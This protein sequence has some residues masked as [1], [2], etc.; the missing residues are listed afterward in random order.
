MLW[1]QT[2]L[3]EPSTTTDGSS[4]M[5]LMSCQLCVCVLQVVCKYLEDP[6]LFNREEVGMV[7]FD[8]RYML[9][10]RSVE[11]LHVYAYNV[12]WLRFANRYDMYSSS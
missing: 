9:M 6:V 1:Y 10:L 2:D 5:V 11:P 3:V 8:I 4:L 7:K 12:F